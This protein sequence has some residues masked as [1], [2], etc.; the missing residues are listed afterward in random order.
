MSKDR[1]NGD[2]NTK[3]NNDEERRKK[4]REFIAKKSK[5]VTS[6]E[7]E[8]ECKVFQFY[9]NKTDPDAQGKFGAVVQYVVTEPNSTAERIWNAS[10]IGAIRAVENKI[11]E[12][13]T[14]LKIRKTGSGSDTKYF[15]DAV[16]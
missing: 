1:R 7:F 8:G 2:S 14:L 6:K 5:F 13:K 12:G 3:D 11:D 4:I 10:A 9:S 16:N 15:A